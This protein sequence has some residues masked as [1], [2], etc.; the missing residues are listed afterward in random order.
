MNNTNLLK[1]NYPQI[2]HLID[3]E[4]RVVAKQ[5]ALAKIENLDIDGFIQI[6]SKEDID[7]GQAEVRNNKV[8]VHQKTQVELKAENDK[9]NNKQSLK[10]KLKALNFTDE[11]I[12]LLIK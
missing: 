2:F 9:V 8:V 5:D 3:K 10:D 7:L 6:E 4:N 12:L 11:E 1:D